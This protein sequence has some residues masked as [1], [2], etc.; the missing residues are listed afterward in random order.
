MLATHPPDRL[1]TTESGT[2]GNAPQ[3]QKSVY[4]GWRPRLMPSG[5]GHPRDAANRDHFGACLGHAMHARL[6]RDF[7]NRGSDA[8]HR[9]GG[10]GAS[11][12]VL[13]CHGPG[14][15]AFPLA[16]RHDRAGWISLSSG[17][18]GPASRGSRIAWLQRPVQP[19][20]RLYRADLSRMGGRT[21]PARLRRAVGRQLPAAQSRRD[22]LGPGVRARTLPHPPEGC[23][24]R[25][26]VFAVAALCAG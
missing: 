16:R 5:I 20:H 15:R 25:P 10:C 4:R 19:R 1:T 6:T 9:R 2:L 13:P 8:Q 21:E 24:R 23:V 3:G 22:V 12:V 14:Q 17:G 7:G 11:V 18:G 26:V